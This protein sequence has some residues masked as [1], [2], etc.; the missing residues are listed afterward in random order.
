MGAVLNY[1]LQVALVMTLLYLA[2]KLFLA[3]TTFFRFNRF[4]LIGIYLV[5]WLVPVIPIIDFSTGNTVMIANGV[6]ISELQ[7]VMTESGPTSGDSFWIRTAIWIYIAGVGISTLLSAIDIFRLRR[8]IKGGDKRIIGGI[9]EVVTPVAPGPFSWG[10]FIILRPEDLNENLSL[11]FAHE[12]AHIA[13]NHWA[14][15]IIAQVTLILQWFSP[16]AWLMMRLM[17]ENHEFEVDRIIAGENPARYQMML[18]KMT[19]GA[20]LPVLADSLNHSQLKKRLTMMMMKKTAPSRRFA[21][22]A[23][24]AFAAVAL[25]ALTQPSVARVTDMLSHT[26]LLPA[27]AAPAVT[28]SKVNQSQASVQM[29]NALSAA[30]PAESDTNSR[31]DAA[32]ETTEPS[33]AS[34]ETSAPVEKAQS[35]ESFPAIFID[36]KLFTGD[37]QS[38]PSDEIGSM[39]VI[40]NDPAYPQ[41]KI[42]IT[43]KKAGVQAGVGGSTEVNAPLAVEKLAEYRGGMQALMQFLG[44]KI[45]CP[46]D[47]NEQKRVIVQFTIDANGNV[48][49]PKVMRSGGE[50]CDAE[51]VNA[52]LAT[53]GNWIPSEKEG[54]PVASTFTLPVNFM[55]G[56]DKD[57]STDKN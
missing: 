11:I 5:A 40:K 3:N 21:T 29:P 13:L 48:K 54:K 10:R 8:M 7:A 18:I 53:S 46:A 47:L 26:T 38:V 44:S 4:V 32:T 43:T 14:D 42:M 31:V 36:G 57:S 15:L 9:T 37:L 49:D 51:A 25:V 12:R 22:L 33:I 41:G 23:L 52:V 50:V 6:E 28:G 30:A 16:S 27:S 35:N 17:K 24:P 2:Y 20:R 19:V 1:M 39:S 55:P 45:T 34:A 56:V